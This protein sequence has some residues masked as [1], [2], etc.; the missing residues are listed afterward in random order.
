[1]AFRALRKRW[2]YVRARRRVARF[3]VVRSP[4]PHG[5]P[6][7]LVVTLTSYP[8]RFPHLA[9]TLRS[10]LDQTVRPDAVILWIAYQDLTQLP[11]DV[12]ALRTHGLE[13]REAADLKSYKKL[14]PAWRE[15]PQRY[16]VTADDDVYY[17]SDWLEGLVEEAR[18]HPRSVIAYR[19]HRAPLDGNGAFLPYSEWD[20]ATDV[21]TIAEPSA[22]LFPTGVGGIL[23][24]PDAFG[25]PFADVALFME[26]APRGDDI[27]FFWT[28]RLAG[29]PQRRT[30]RWFDIVE[31]PNSQDVALYGDNMLGEGNDRQ[32]R[33]MH[34]HFGPVP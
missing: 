22:R 14:L 7:P 11:E 34:E 32:L 30:R 9:K 23:Y 4:R 19:A 16:F 18:L 25:G 13:I 17:P 26:L 21:R 3:P 29:T 33:A 27:W 28:A 12:L 10:L 20:H 5:L 24:P 15:A 8:P 31:W 2:L 6:A 1:M